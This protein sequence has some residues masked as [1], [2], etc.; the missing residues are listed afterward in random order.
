MKTK[1]KL[2]ITALLL[3]GA[4]LLSGC[5]GA[6]EK[7][8]FYA[9]PFS[10]NNPGDGGAAT[11]I[12][13]YSMLKSALIDLI[14]NHEETAAFRFSRYN[15]SVADDVAAACLEVRTTNP[16]GAYAVD[17]LTCDT[18]RIVSYYTADI[19]VTYKKT[20]EEIRGIVGVGGVTELRERLQEAVTTSAPRAVLRV[21]S[22]QV[23]EEYIASLITDFH[24][25]DPV[26]VVTRPV[27]E[28]TSY[29]GEGI[30]RIYDV[31]LDYGAA[32]DKLR[33]MS[34]RLA[35]RVGELS[36]EL[37][38]D[39]QPKLALDCANQ[40]FELLTGGS[41]AYP[42]TAYGALV[43]G[44]ADSEGVA[45]AYNALCDAVGIECIV[46]RGNIGTM[47]AEE[48]CWNIIGLEGEYYHAD[49]SAFAWGNRS[50]AFLLDD[51]GLWGIYLWDTEIY[52]ACTG[53][54]RYTDLVPVIPP[55]PQTEEESEESETPEEPPPEETEAPP[56][57]TAPEPETTE[58]PPPEETEPPPESFNPDSPG[59]SAPS[60]P[61]NG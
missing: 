50:A 53:K 12:G 28:I 39:T 25:K 45:L 18:S 17:T 32:P 61:W 56:E 6:F 9:A 38:A 27:P 36:G 40:L 4:L 3:A 55:A 10:Y 31:S 33:E 20:A 54:L 44:F 41:G 29:P 21:Y 11:E 5:S 34:E 52:P 2:Y 30:N 37:D 57:E 60:Q 46:V 51:A 47:G 42:D 48:R 22:A 16:L 43:E 58:A 35:A 19:Q 13:N 26:T 14:N 8:Y 59:Q 49:V 24:D 23:D 15:G 7:E 1:G